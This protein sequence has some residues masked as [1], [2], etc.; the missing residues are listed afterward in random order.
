ML[1]GLLAAILT[2]YTVVPLHI[3]F[4][5]PLE[6]SGLQYVDD[7]H[8]SGSDG[9]DIGLTVARRSANKAGA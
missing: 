9:G 1:D 3:S 6:L 5:I 8:G 4:T 7:Q 2:G